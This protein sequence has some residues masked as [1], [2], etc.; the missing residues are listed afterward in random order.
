MGNDEF[1]EL[2]S[3]NR[4]A[5]AWFVFLFFHHVQLCYPRELAWHR[6]Y[7]IRTLSRGRLV[8]TVADFFFTDAQ[9]S[10]ILQRVRLLSIDRRPIGVVVQVLWNPMVLRT[11]HRC[12]QAPPP[13]SMPPLTATWARRHDQCSM[14]LNQLDLHRNCPLISKRLKP[15]G[16]AEPNFA[17]ATVDATSG[18]VP[19]QASEGRREEC[20]ICSRMFAAD[21]IA[22]HKQVCAK[23]NSG[24]R[25]VFDMQEHRVRVTYA[26]NNAE[27]DADRALRSANEN[28]EELKRSK[29]KRPSWRQ[30]SNALQNAMKSARGD[31]DAQQEEDLRVECA[32]CGRRF[33]PDTAETHIPKCIEKARN[34]RR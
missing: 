5:I 28:P 1:K 31:A 4:V 25:K 19:A 2:I 18:G 17:N 27:E 14:R 21:R 23:A 9:P 15:P 13:R 26:N 34:G 24:E 22:K 10:Q 29:N 8:S 33:A 12:D 11:R 32:G 3:S 6:C 16:H 30:Q 20:D 7:T